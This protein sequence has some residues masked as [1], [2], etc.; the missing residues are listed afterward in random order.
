MHPYSTIQLP[1]HGNT[2]IIAHRGLSGLYLENTMQA[3]KAAGKASYYGIESDVHVTRDGRFI[4]FHD[5]NTRRLAKVNLKIEDSDYN[6]LRLLPIKFHRMPSLKEY[7]SCCRD[8]KKIAVLELKNPMTKENISGIISEIKEIGYI[9]ETVF[10]SF[11][12][13]NLFYIRE[14]I[15]NQP[16]QFLT[17]KFDSKTLQFLIA[18]RFDLDIEYTALDSCVIELCHDNGIKVNCWTVNELADAQRL[19]EYGVDFIT[20][21]II[22]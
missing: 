4:V 5:D 13:E 3:F 21:N 18:N 1:E 7:I 15:G 12:A 11:A 22:E 16:V 6:T 20:T 8:Y 17:K 10:I 2:K 9:E 19:V 14:I